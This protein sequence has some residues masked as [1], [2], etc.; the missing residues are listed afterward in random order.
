MQL[1]RFC[2]TMLLARLLRPEDFGL[3]AMILVLSESVAMFKDMGLSV[4]TIQREKITH[5]QVSTLFWINLLLSSVLALFLLASAPLVAMFYGRPELTAV[6]AVLCASFI[7]G[8]LG[9]QHTALLRRHMR[10][11]ALAGIEVSAEIIA[12]GVTIALVWLGWGYWA[13]VAR[14]I[15]RALSRFILSFYFCPWVPG[16]IK[17]GAGVRGM[18]AFGGHITG[19]G[20][21]NYFARNL[22][23]VLIGRFIGADPLGLY[24]KAYGLF[25]MPVS[26]IRGPMM[27]VALPALSSIRADPARYRRYYRLFVELLASLTIPVT[28]YLIV[29]ADFVVGALLG[30]QWLR[31]VPVFRILSIVGLIQPVA[32]TRGLVLL[33]SGFSRRY[34]NWGLFNA[35]MTVIAFVSGL[36][37]GIEGVAVAYAIE[38]YAILL[39]SLF[40]CFHNTPVTVGLFLRSLA[41]PLV[42]GVLAAAAL[43]WYVRVDDSAGVHVVGLLLFTSVYLGVSACRRSVRDIVRTLLRGRSARPGSEVGGL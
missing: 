25:L 5:Q 22:D 11:G 41:M 10:F 37:F 43:A 34:F 32:G 31:A 20:F 16:P 23:R 1:I 14:S 9:I 6:T 30:P 4:V 19:F 2:S 17:K 36:R 13:L 7:M 35:L 21:A 8:G 40:Y 42:T 39:P 18:L 27:Q 24:A 29:E 28:L 33:S 38:N 15:I 26:Q 12:F 3:I